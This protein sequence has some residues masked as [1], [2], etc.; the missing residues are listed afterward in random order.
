MN[1][2]HF[3]WHSVTDPDKEGVPPFAKILEQAHAAG[4]T[5]LVIP[6]LDASA[7]KTADDY[8]RIAE[9]CNEAAIQAT[10]AG[11][12]LAYHNHNFEFSPLEGGTTGFEVF[13]ADFASA[14]KF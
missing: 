5:H 7:R 4:L 12:Q 10:A 9:R 14:M 1:S 8:R 11:I 6:Y 13:M 3:A 2:S